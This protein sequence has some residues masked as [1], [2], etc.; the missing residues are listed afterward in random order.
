M[1]EVTRKG[2]PKRWTIANGS[3]KPFENTVKPTR[4]TRACIAVYN[5]TY[6]RIFS[7]SKFW[8][9]VPLAYSTRICWKR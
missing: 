4:R 7:Y 1:E 5:H 3:I 8:K 2:K 6:Y 9:K